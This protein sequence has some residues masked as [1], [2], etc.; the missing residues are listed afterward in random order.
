LADELLASQEGLIVLHW[1]VDRH[2]MKYFFTLKISNMAML[3]NLEV[4]CCKITYLDAINSGLLG[5]YAV[6]LGSN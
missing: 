5:C 2:N 3:R 6:S 4:L 1:Y